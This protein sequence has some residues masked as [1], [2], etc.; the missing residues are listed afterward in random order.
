MNCGWQLVVM[1]LAVGCGART[2][3]AGEGLDGGEDVPAN[4]SG[5]GCDPIPN[6]CGHGGCDDKACQAW[7]QSVAGSGY[8]HAGIVSEI[9]G[10][11]LSCGNGDVCKWSQDDARFECFCGGRG[12]ADNEVCVSD[13]PDGPATCRAM[14]VPTC[15]LGCS[16]S[17]CVCQTDNVGAD[18]CPAS[19]MV[20]NQ[21]EVG[22][23]ACLAG[24][25]DAH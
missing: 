1:T 17:V 9:G 5:G 19:G 22:G 25:P 16:A 13:T 14:C 21:P 4:D 23:S 10:G 2:M 11:K 3:L 8:A 15:G 7:A 6:P 12:C 18:V 20:C 24:C